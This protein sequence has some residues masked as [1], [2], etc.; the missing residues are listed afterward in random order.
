MTPALQEAHLFQARLSASARRLAAVRRRLA[1]H[2]PQDR[3]GV[4]TEAFFAN[5]AER[6][7]DELREL[8]AALAPGGTV[9]TSTWGRMERM[10]SDLGRFLE[11][12]FG[13]IAAR[14]LMDHQDGPVLHRAAEGLLEELGRDVG[15]S[16]DGFVLPALRWVLAVG[17]RVIRLPFPLVGPWELPVLAHEFGHV[18]EGEI[19]GPSGLPEVANVVKD[20]DR[21]AH[22]SELFADF[23]AA[24]TTGPAYGFAALVLNLTPGRTG[25][26]DHPDDSLRAEWILRTLRRRGE[27]VGDGEWDIA[28]DGL[29]QAWLA[30]AAPAVFDED[31]DVDPGQDF[32]EALFDRFHDILRGVPQV[33][34]D[35]WLRALNLGD[36]LA[37]G[38]IP[39]LVANT[40]LRDVLNGAWVARTAR[41][42][43]ESRIR[44]GT[45][46]LLVRLGAS[47]R[48]RGDA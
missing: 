18:V 10:E 22:R 26:A 48:G 23:Y 42:D 24:W 11:E 29:E 9:N 19:R 17:P 46:E 25:G 5:G 6:L 41:P 40:T 34:Y 32:P 15:V 37:A 47:Q 8:R 12:V 39:E 3:P 20:G 13:L 14:N 35:G 1:D 31:D 43:E 27:A 30:A 2:G 36:D 38:R 7:Q 21:P 16:W 28:V 44:N 33:A 45:T 4:R